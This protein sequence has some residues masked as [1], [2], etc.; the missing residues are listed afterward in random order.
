[1]RASVTG[2]LAAAVLLSGCATVR[3][4]R[5]NP[6]NWFGGARAPA[7]AAQADGNALIPQ[8]GA[9]ARPE[10]SYEGAAIARVSDL[11]LEPL[12]GGAV[13]RATGVAERQGPYEVRLTPVQQEGPV[14]VFRFDRLLPRQRTPAGPPRT[15]EVTVA[16]HLSELELDGVRAIRV[17]AAGNARELRR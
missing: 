14:L 16:T 10:E 4:S 3:D 5:I 17:E 13:L 7:E 6:V 1:M 9:L 8:R 11:V 12:P 2:L 15:R